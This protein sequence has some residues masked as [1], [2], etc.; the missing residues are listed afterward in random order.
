MEWTDLYGMARKAIRNKSTRPLNVYINDEHALVF[1]QALRMLTKESGAVVNGSEIMMPGRFVSLDREAYYKYL[2]LYDKALL[3]RRKPAG[4][5][6]HILDHH[7][8]VLRDEANRVDNRTASEIIR[9]LVVGLTNE[10]A[11]A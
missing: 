8:G 1:K 9:L 11:S 6:A 2:Y 7:I 3:T 10:F 5:L 4:A